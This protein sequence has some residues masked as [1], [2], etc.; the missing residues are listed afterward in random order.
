M[1][2]IHGGAFKAG[3]G[4]DDTYGPEFLVRHDVILVTFNYRLEVLG[5]LCLDTEDV[6]GNAGMKDQVA[7]LR[8]VHKNIQHFGGDP[9]N[10]TIFGNSAGSVSVSYHLVSPMS[11]GLFKKAIA[12]SGASTCWIGLVSHPRERALALAKKLGL[13]SENNKEL[14]EFF[15][16]LPVEKLVNAQTSVRTA[17][18]LRIPEEIS[19][20]VSSEKKFD[21]EETFFHGDPYSVLRNGIHKGV[22]V[23][24]GYT[25]DEGIFAVGTSPDLEKVYELANSLADYVVPKP[26]AENCSSIAQIQAGKKILKFY[27][28]DDEVSKVKI[29]AL[30]KYYSMYYFCYGTYQWAKICSS[31]KRNK[32][33]LY[34]FTCLTERNIMSKMLGAAEFIG[35]RPVVCHGDD[36]CY[37]FPTKIMNKVD[38]D[39]ETF[40]IIDRVTKL[41][42][43]M[44]KYG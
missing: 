33:Y 37:I 26:I 10:V 22:D 5:F 3:N 32:I 42:T 23:I 41:W 19:F 6:P 27:F 43:N 11:K 38:K 40:K 16:S 9:N 18:T 36:V 24:T 30:I 4:N 25:A 44:A 21:G 28:E 14:Y 12:Q 31:L 8:W 39:S 15:K 35:S 17:E 1:F 29:D 2:W 13:K 20:L 7:A 34:K